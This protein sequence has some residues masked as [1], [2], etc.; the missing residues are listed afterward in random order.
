[1]PQRMVVTA[2]LQAIWRSEGLHREDLAGQTRPKWKHWL[3]LGDVF[4]RVVWREPCPGILPDRWLEDAWFP[5]PPG[6]NVSK[7]HLHSFFLSSAKGPHNKLRIPHN[8]LNRIVHCTFS[9]SPASE[10][11]QTF[12]K[13][14]MLFTQQ[15]SRGNFVLFVSGGFREVMPCWLPEAR[16]HFILA[17]A[18]LHSRTQRFRWSAGLPLPLTAT[19]SCMRQHCLTA[20]GRAVIKVHKW[21]HS[22]PLS[23]HCVPHHPCMGVLEYIF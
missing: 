18:V 1:M 5:L 11:A 21:S 8:T 4:V 22:I 7:K 14:T 17:V 3:V 16:H 23:S 12:L 10:C 20:G 9:P 2:L 19:T 13:S 15:T 6:S